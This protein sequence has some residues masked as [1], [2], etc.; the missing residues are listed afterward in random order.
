MMK[1]E[2]QKF[3]NYTNRKVDNLLTSGTEKLANLL[4]SGTENLANLLTPVSL[5]PESFV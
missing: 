3:Q 1:N 5:Q 2:A 4:T